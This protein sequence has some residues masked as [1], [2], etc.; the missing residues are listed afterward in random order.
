MDIKL[1]E[2]LISEKMGLVDFYKERYSEPQRFYHTWNHVLD[3][4]GKAIDDNKLSDELLLAIVFHDIVYDPMNND[5]E[6]KS[7]ELFKTFFNYP[8]VYEA[9]LATKNHIDVNPTSKLLNKYDLSVLY[10]D[11]NSFMKYEDGIFKEYQFVDVKTY[12]ENRIKFLEKHF[13]NIKQ[14]YLDYIKYRKYNIG[15]YAGSF[16]PFHVGHYDILKKAEAI[17]DKVIIARGINT[18]KSDELLP[19]TNTLKN[20]QA[21]LYTGLLTDFID[22]LG[23][24]VTLIRGLRNASDLE[25]EKTQYRYLKDLKPDI[26]VINILSDSEFEHVSSSSIKMLQKYG[27][28]DKY[29]I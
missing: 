17:F 19:L 20:R 24:D 13:G 4:I 18:S 22:G 2:E 16:N 25:F 23:Y 10:G 26:K 1:I 15:V 28:G 12:T 8:D 27:K 14:E 6:E 7:A 9:I 21:G 5:N 3:L 11:F 29:L